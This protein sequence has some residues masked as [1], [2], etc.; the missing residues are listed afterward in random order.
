MSTEE[1][2][3]EFR[4]RIALYERDLV[5]SGSKHKVQAAISM[6]F[7]QYDHIEFPEELRLALLIINKHKPKFMQTY[8]DLKDGN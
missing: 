5:I 6:E 3:K 7:P 4:E 2:L 1:A 8:K